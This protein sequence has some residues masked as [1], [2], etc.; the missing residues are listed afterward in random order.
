M[1]MYILNYQYCEGYLEKRTPYRQDHF[2][3]ASKYIEAGQLLVAG[4]Y[5]NPADGATLIFKNVESAAV[6]DEFAKNDPYTQNDIVTGWTVRE[7]TIAVGSEL[8][9]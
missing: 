9:E 6:L 8:F 1:S 7:W 5:A 3:H 2:A 4:A